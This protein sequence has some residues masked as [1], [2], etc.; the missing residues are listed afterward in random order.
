MGHLRITG[1]VLRGRRIRVPKG[2]RPTSSRV[3]EALFSI[4][5][6]RV[7]GC[8]FLDLFAGSGAVGIEAVSRGAGFAQLVEGNSGTF[9]VL[10]SNLR[11]VEDERLEARLLE[12]PR[13]LEK[14][15]S[16]SS[17]SFDLI[18]VDPPY[19]FGDLEKTLAG[20]ETLLA[21]GGE[22]AIEHSRR[23]TLAESSGGLVAV[24]ERAYGESAVTFYRRLRAA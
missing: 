20:C 7:G 8:H 24:D 21:E 1:G 15:R 23:R 22:L 13:E 4:W 9:R 3:R 10:F 18:F 14:I 12:L 2:A 16:Q 5:S 19:S 6:E 11:D 17:V